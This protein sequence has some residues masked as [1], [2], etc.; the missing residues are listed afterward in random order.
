MLSVKHLATLLLLLLAVSLAAV[1]AYTP[2]QLLFKTTDNIQVKQDKTG[3]ATFDSYLQSFGVKSIQPMRGMPGNRYFKVNLS[4][5]PDVAQMKSLS[6]AGIEYVEPNYLRKL[7]TVPNDPMFARQLHHLSSIPQAWSYTT[8]NRQI[9]VGVIDSG[10]LINHPDLK[11]N[12]YINPHEI[13][14][15]GI[16]DDGNG[17]ID[18]WCGWDFVHA[19]EM[20]DV[21]LGDYLDPDNDVNDENYHGTHVSGIIG[22]RGNNGIG[23]SGVCWDISILPLRAGFRTST[24]DGYLQD[25]DAAAAII[26]AADNGAHVVNMSWG[27]P[28]Y[29][30]IIADA[31]EY[32]YDRGVTLVASAGNTPGPILSYPAKL[33]TVI[34]V[35]SVN[36]AKILSGFSSYG[37]DLD[38]V[39]PGELILSTYKDSGSDMYMEMSG[40]SMSAPYV[41]GSIALLLSLVPGLSPAEVRARLLSATDDLGATGFDIQTG[42][43]LL[44]VQKL[45]DNTNPP[46]VEITDPIDQIGV[47]STVQISGSVYGEDFARYT[48]MY[49]SITD[50]S[51]TDW[52]DAREHTSQPLY[53]TQQV[54]NG[55]LGEFYIPPSFPEG[56]YMLRLQYQKL[57][58]NLMK[59]N[60]FRTITVDRSIP[61]LRPEKLGGFS[62]YDRANLRFYISAGFDE[63]VITELDVYGSDGYHTKV[64]GT[65]RDSLQVWALP[66]DV[67]QGPISIRFSATNSANLTYTSQLYEDFME[68]VYNSVPTH[69][70]SHQPIGKA[71][72]PLNRWVDFNGSGI[73]EYVAM[74]IPLAGYGQ[75]FSYEPHNNVHTQTNWFGDTGWPLDIGNTNTRGLELLL[76]KADTA[77]LWETPVGA[78]YPS[79]DSLLWTDPGITGGTMADYDGNGTTDLLLVKNLPAERVIQIYSRNT[80]GL[81]SAR[82]TLR[83]TTQTNLRNNFIP[84]VIVAN[85]DG[86]NRKDILTADTDGDVMIFEVLNNAEAPMTWHYRMPVANTYQ[87]ASGDFNGDGQTDFIVGGYNTN[88]LNPNLN[89]WYFE[90]FTA[91]GN[92]D[93]QSMGHVMFNGVISQN[94]IVVMDMDGD[95]QDEIVL[96]ISPSLYVLKYMNGEFVPVFMG[97]SWAN[98][99][100]AAFRDQSDK[101]W[102]ITNYQ[103]SADSLIAV[104]W[105][106]DAPFSGPGTPVNFTAAPL[107]ESDVLLSWI[108]QDAD[109][110]RIY[111]KN[112]AGEISLIDNVVGQSYLDSGLIPAHA[113]RYAIAAVHL[114]ENPSESM[115][116]AWLEAIPDLPPF[117]ESITMAGNRELRLIFNQV[118]PSRFLSPGYYSVSPYLGRP[119]SANSIAQNRGVQLR[120]RDEIPVIDSLFTLHLEGIFG[121]SGVPMQQLDYSFA[122]IPDLEAPRIIA[123]V[124]SEDRKHLHIHFSEELALSSAQYLGNYTLSCP[125]NDPDNRI[126]AVSA[127]GDKIT[128]SLSHALRHSDQAY[129]IRVEFVTDLSGNVI[130]PQHNLARFALRDIKDLSD[131]KV[132][133]NPVNRNQQSEMVFL[134]FPPHKKGRIAIYSAAGNLVFKA[135]IGPFNPDNN[136]ITWR[137]NLQNNNGRRVSSGVY[138]YLIE[139]DDERAKGKIA[140]IN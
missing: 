53:H 131:L 137:W 66:S 37:H 49:R 68:I 102:A 72:V 7:H 82:N 96:G 6:F 86:D 31:C 85:L 8:G 120:F 75:I 83:N 97:D 74:D 20:A 91:V 19:P 114:Q 132:Y 16:D 39:A 95:G 56:T 29:S 60:Y 94:A 103:V 69:G 18:D 63:A 134:N 129:Y 28:N 2:G 122:Y 73:P 46:F 84:T 30:A 92:N 64:F 135:D 98:Y 5:M 125:A 55:R 15:N 93:Y 109:F 89:Y 51:M 67:P 44:N 10:L 106:I 78:L 36:S 113:Y 133:P 13:P 22:A 99:R 3:L 17:Y 76:I 25:D 21:A 126:V 14:D 117:V 118:L 33:S 11:D 110:Y 43:G 42:H 34:S 88:I 61:V 59:Y 105:G 58:N 4:V 35:G 119:N 112:E 87:L 23:I 107:N 136:R 47:N 45:L 100:M 40:T 123:T 65:L 71:R 124:I 115:P 140:V 127:N 26:Y 41:T 62:R 111:R 108:P 12:V 9:I 80:Q 48:L 79:R 32:A 38:L 116:S 81:L 121:H 52:K 1:P 128:I 57:Q 104:Q 101:A 50:P 54:V 90:A 24:G 70:Y 130:S 139:M 27:D 77:H 138:Y